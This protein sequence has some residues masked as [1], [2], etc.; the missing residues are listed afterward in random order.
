M[1]SRAE[2]VVRLRELGVP[3]DVCRSI[4]SELLCD[5]DRQDFEEAIFVDGGPDLILDTIETLLPMF[6]IATKLSGFLKGNESEEHRR[7]IGIEEARQIEFEPSI[8]ANEIE[9]DSY[10]LEEDA[11]EIAGRLTCSDGL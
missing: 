9:E 8:E 1:R 5:N 3:Q 4:L 7:T 11:Q 6:N 10:S 2:I